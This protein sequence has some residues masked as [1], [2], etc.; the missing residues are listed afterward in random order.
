[1]KFEVATCVAPTGHGAPGVKV[2]DVEKQIVLVPANTTSGFWTAIWT[3]LFDTVFVPSTTVNL[4]M[5]VPGASYTCAATG[6]VA[7]LRLLLPGLLPLPQLVGS[8]F[9]SAAELAD[10]L[11]EQLVLPI[12]SREHLAQQPRLLDI[13]A[14]ARRRGIGGRRDIDLTEKGRTDSR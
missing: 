12:L 7:V 10:Q 1:M 9:L 3:Q 2:P 11:F 13:L 14:A 4:R 6:P 5:Y 8:L